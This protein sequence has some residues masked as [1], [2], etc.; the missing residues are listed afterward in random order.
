MT[1]YEPLTVETYGSVEGLT[2]D[3]H[4]DDYDYDSH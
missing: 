1:D 3:E 4:I 2:E